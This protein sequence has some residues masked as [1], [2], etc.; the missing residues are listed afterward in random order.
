MMV[1]KYKKQGLVQVGDYEIQIIQRQIP[2]GK[3]QIDVGKTFFYTGGIHLRVDLVGNT[4][5]FQG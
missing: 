3:D 5:N 1:A 4:E 2:R